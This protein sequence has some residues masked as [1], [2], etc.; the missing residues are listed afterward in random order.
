MGMVGIAMPVMSSSCWRSSYPGSGAA[1]A[2]NQER[3]HERLLLPSEF[4]HVAYRG[5]VD[6]DQAVK[7][8]NRIFSPDPS[9]PRG[10]DANVSARH[11]GRWCGNRPGGRCSGARTAQW[12]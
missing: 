4:H 3:A 1:K 11:S 2:A 5:K 10:A 9:Q 7:H 12:C 8:L 6:L